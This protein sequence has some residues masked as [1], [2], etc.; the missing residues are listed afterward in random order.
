[1]SLEASPELVIFYTLALAL[2]FGKFFEEIVSRTKY[3]PVLGDLIAGL[4]L[5]SSVLGIYIVNDVVH[6]VSWLGVALL[7]FYAGLNTSYR[8]FLRLLPIA[9]LLTLG[10]ALAAFLMGFLVGWILGYNMLQSFFIGAVLEATSVSLTV[11]TLMDLGKLDSIEGY[12]IMEIA[13]L[14][15]LASLITISIGASIVV[16]GSLELPSIIVTLFEAIGVWFAV[17]LI[18]HRFSDYIIRLASR[19][20]VEESMVSIL[21]AVFASTAY[22][23]SRVGVSPLIG[24]YASGL[25]LSEVR[26]LRENRETIRKLAIVF[27][28][29][30]FVTTAAELDLREALKPELLGF[31]ILVVVAAFIGKLLGAGLTSYLLGFP[32]RSSLRVAVGLFPRCEFAII[33]AYTAVSYGVIGVELYL[34]ALV[35]VLATNLVTPPLLRIVYSGGVE[36]ESV[37]LRIK[38]VVLKKH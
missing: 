17:L 8:E 29:V 27:S 25:A 38:G 5:G 11:R 2:L 20:H 32:P 19:M 12:T 7:L 26:G 6:A 16:L 22:L 9:G 23:V 28:T 14:D 37:R 35:I 1:M 18:L 21:I 15:D 3:P 13:V 33:A 24:A 34:V 10:E 30:F 4:L 31:Y 36:Y